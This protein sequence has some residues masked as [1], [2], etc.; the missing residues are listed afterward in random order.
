[1]L[2]PRSPLNLYDMQDGTRVFVKDIGPQMRRKTLFLTAYAGPLLVHMLCY[3]AQTTV[4]GI[5]FDHTESQVLAFT[6]ITLHLAKRIF[7]TL[8]VHV[9]YRVTVSVY[10]L[11]MHV[12]HWWVLCGCFMGYYIYYPSAAFTPPTSSAARSLRRYRQQLSPASLMHAARS[13][14]AA[15]RN[16][17]TLATYYSPLGMSGRR[18]PRGFGF[19][20]VSC[21][22][23]FFEILAWTT[24]VLITRSFASLIFLAASVLHMWRRAVRKHDMYRKE[25]GAQYP[26]HRRILI[27]YV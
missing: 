22:N 18:I 4:Y 10:S 11:Y 5:P 27:P 19:D 7:E 25:F 13:R 21:P 15:A 12:F 8:F 9:F 16:A 6:L 3:Y 17:A 20:L 24:V 1:V 26:E 23:Y 14:T 2:D